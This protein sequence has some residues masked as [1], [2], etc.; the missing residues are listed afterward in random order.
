MYQF[1]MYLW[2]YVCMVGQKDC[3]HVEARDSLQSL[4][5]HHVGSENWTG[6]ARSGD[7]CF[8]YC[9]I[10]LT[11]PFSFHAWELQRRLYCFAR[12][13]ILKIW[14]GGLW[15]I[16]WYKFPW[17]KSQNIKW[18]VTVWRG[19]APSKTHRLNAWSWAVFL[20]RGEW[21]QLCHQ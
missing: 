12:Y 5:F 21:I 13:N 20:L 2:I 1:I 15:M 4:L 11:R 10:F 17:E 14:P 6:V 3:K 16:T 7:K 19:S 8:K 18:L 9:T